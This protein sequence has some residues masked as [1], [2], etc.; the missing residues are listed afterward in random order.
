M[1]KRNQELDL[2]TTGE[3]TYSSD[4]IKTKKSKNKSRLSRNDDLFDLFNRKTPKSNASD[5]KKRE[6]LAKVKNLCEAEDQDENENYQKILKIINDN[7]TPW[8]KIISIKGLV[9]QLNKESLEKNIQETKKYKIQNSY[10]EN[11]SNDGTKNLLDNE[12]DK[13]ESNGNDG[14]NLISNN[15]SKHDDVQWMEYINNSQI[16]FSKL[17]NSVNKFYISLTE[18]LSQHQE[19]IWEEIEN[20]IPIEEDL[21]LQ[22]FKDEIWKKKFIDLLRIFRDSFNVIF[23]D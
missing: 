11:E 14:Y 8:K 17:I 1:K 9:I 22:K 12:S 4:S 2:G 19:K 18:P 15:D 23:F 13:N 6:F 3:K 21:K 16:E 7:L 5:T 20:E 10:N